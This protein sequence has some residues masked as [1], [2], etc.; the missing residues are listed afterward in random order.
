VSGLREGAVEAP[1]WSKFVEFGNP[2]GIE[3]RIWPVGSGAATMLDIN[4]V[5]RSIKLL[6]PKNGILT[7]HCCK[8]A[9]SSPYSKAPFSW[10]LPRI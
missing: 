7:A 9:P 1:Y 3:L 6:S 8:A 5:P 10:G 2:D 4:R